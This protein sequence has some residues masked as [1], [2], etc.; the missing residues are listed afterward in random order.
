MTDDE[1]NHDEWD[2]DAEA[3]IDEDGDYYRIYNDER[4]QYRVYDSESW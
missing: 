2:S 3:Y 4:G 1:W